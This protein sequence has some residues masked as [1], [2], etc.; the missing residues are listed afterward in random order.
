MQTLGATLYFARRNDEAIDILRKALEIDPNFPSTY[1]YL[2]FSHI[3]KGDVNEA[4]TWVEKTP[5]ALRIPPSV[6]LRAVL[7]GIAG[8]REDATRMLSDL[9]R[10]AKDRYVSPHHFAMIHFALGDMDA[11]HTALW[12]AYEE[13]A[14]SLVMFKVM[15]LL[16]PMRSD[17]VFQE[18][19]RKVGLP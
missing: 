9:E 12:Q 11:W 16:D 13:R 6:G 10:L 18:I 7:F 1:V 17:P 3:A 15:P 8:R 5:Y 2:A 19:I 4:V 14:N